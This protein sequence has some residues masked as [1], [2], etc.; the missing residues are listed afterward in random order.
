[1]GFWPG[2]C[3]VGLLVRRLGAWALMLGCASVGW[4][5]DAATGAI[6]GVVRDLGGVGVRGAEVRVVSV[7]TG[8][9]RVLR[10]GGKG[11]FWAA[12]L[13]AGRYL[14]RMEVAG[15][16]AEERVVTVEVGGTTAVALD[17][18]AGVVRQTV[19]VTAGDWT[20]T[21]MGRGGRLGRTDRVGVGWGRRRRRW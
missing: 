14:V 15:G 4:G 2:S 10:S 9:G 17:V 3:R 19:E 5:Q 7:G 1:M 6:S 13:G 16:S 18:F 21:R 12:G 20:R 8:V 11:E